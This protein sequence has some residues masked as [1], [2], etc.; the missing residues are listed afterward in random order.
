M[1]KD[2]LY[3]ITPGFTDPNKP[4][5]QF[6]C[7]FCNQIEGL[8]KS[9]PE[10]AEKVDI[11]RVGFLRPRRPVIDAIGEANQSLPVIVFGGNPPGDAKDHLG[12][13]FVNDTTRIL[14]LLS[15]RHGFPRLH[16]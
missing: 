12:V 16:A 1:A 11:E 8:I 14:E 10:L 7:P 2:K 4:G 5:T 6:V 9:F 15:E 13:S 3:L